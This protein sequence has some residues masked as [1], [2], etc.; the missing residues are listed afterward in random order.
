VQQEEK[1]WSAMAWSEMRCADLRRW[2]VMCLGV[3]WGQEYF[4]MNNW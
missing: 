4:A 3:A 2:L 1:G